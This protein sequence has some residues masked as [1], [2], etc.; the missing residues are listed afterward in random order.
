VATLAPARFRLKARPA[1]VVGALAGVAAMA[2]GQSAALVD[3]GDEVTTGGI[4]WD[5]VSGADSYKLY[6]GTAAGSLTSSQDVG[7]VTS[8]DWADLSPRMAQGTTYY[9]QVRTID[10]G[11]ESTAW[12]TT[13]WLDGAQVG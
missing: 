7:N 8:F 2:F 4:Q 3:A 12:G 9:V 5:A 11:V 6:W 13:V 1:T 10:G